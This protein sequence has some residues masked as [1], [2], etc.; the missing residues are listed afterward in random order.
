MTRRFLNP[1]FLFA[2][3]DFLL[4]FAAFCLASPLRFQL[5]VGAA[6]RYLGPV[7]PRATTF[8][9]LVML[10]LLAMGLYRARQRPRLWET[11]ARVIIGVTV[12]A[13]CCVLLFYLVPDLNSGRGVLAGAVI[14]SCVLVSIGRLFLL[15]FIDKNPVKTR[16]MV[17]G[18]GPHALKIGRLRR[19][20]DRRRFEIVGY[21]ALTEEDCRLAEQNPELRPIVRIEQ[22]ADYPGI[23]EVVVAL[24]ER[25]GML[26]LDLLLQFK[27]RGVPV[28]DI[29]DFLE[30]ETG[31]IDL[32]LLSPSWFVYTQAGYTDALFRIVKR[33]VDIVLS[34]IVFAVTSPIFA[35]VVAL[36]W[37]EDGIRAPLLYRQRRVGLGGREFELLKFRSMTVDAEATTGPRW[38]VKNDARVTTIGK[39]MRRLRVDELPQLLNIIRGEM[40]IVGPRPERPEFVELL[41]SEVSMFS[42]RHNMRPGLTG[43][44]QLNFPYGASVV[45]AKEKLS[46]DIYYIKNASVTLDLLI[47]LQTIEVVIWGKAIS[48]AG[49]PRPRDSKC[50]TE[51]KKLS[52]PEIEAT[53]ANVTKMSAAASGIISTEVDADSATQPSSSAGGQT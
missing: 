5:D 10:G 43:W 16:I 24:D 52:N 49:S 29:I 48:M 11:V 23:N 15:R 36:I 31:K 25:R 46:Y 35:L 13:I 39:L 12:G 53:C 42:V 40:S 3:L 18:T 19:A 32:D 45:D 30:R 2:S 38:S 22:V 51:G 26:P 44:A 4:A 8:G 34:T 28:T 41:A 33:V 37:I 6:E 14:A 21:A 47:F 20:S 9:V 17:L 27:G 50:R 1:T 7:L